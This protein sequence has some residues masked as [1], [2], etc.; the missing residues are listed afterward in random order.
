MDLGFLKGKS[1]VGLMIYR[2]RMSKN[3]QD[4]FLKVANGEIHK[5]ETRIE[6]K[7]EREEEK[8]E[9]VRE[10]REDIN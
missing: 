7:K 9:R 3:L 10:G 4:W 1:E 5:T 6:I 8:Q 2:L